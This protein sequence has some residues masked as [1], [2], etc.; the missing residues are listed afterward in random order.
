VAARN[1]LRDTGLPDLPTIP[2]A[3]VALPDATSWQTKSARYVTLPIGSLIPVAAEA[4]LHLL[5]LQKGDSQFPYPVLPVPRLARGHN[6]QYRPLVR[7]LAYNQSQWYLP[8][9]NSEFDRAI[10][11]PLFDPI[12]LMADPKTAELEILNLPPHP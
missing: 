5:P 6:D 8:C 2:L 9:I 1:R 4:V 10:S 11:Y 7:R 12:P 3:V